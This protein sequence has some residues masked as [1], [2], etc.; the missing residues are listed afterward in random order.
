[1]GVEGLTRENVASHLQKFRLQLRRDSGS[2]EVQDN[3]DTADSDKG[4]AVTPR[5]PRAGSDSAGAG[6]AVLWHPFLGRIMQMH[7]LMVIT[8]QKALSRVIA[9]AKSRGRVSFG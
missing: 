3:G 8:S 2:K 6:P 7:V 9:L 4:A 5:Q 1:M